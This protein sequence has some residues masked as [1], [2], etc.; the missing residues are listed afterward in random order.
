[1][2]LTEHRADRIVLHNLSWQQFE[3]LLPV[4]GDKRRARV[5]YLD[6]TLEIMTSLPEHE[7][8][9]TT[10][11]IVIEDAA[12]ELALDYECYGSTTWRRQIKQAG[13]EPDNCFYF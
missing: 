5:A 12:E 4:L 9:K 8:F 3:N 11:S 7:Y 2:L 10:I 1:M 13:L 6:G